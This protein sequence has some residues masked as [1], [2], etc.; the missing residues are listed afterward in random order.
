MQPIFVTGQVTDDQL[1]QIRAAAPGVEVRYF[2]TREE[3]EARIE[4]AEVVAGNIAAP[5]L[6]RATQLRWVQSWAAGPDT[7]MYPEM[8]AS[9]V[10]CT[11]CK[12]NGAIPLAEH[13]MMLMLMLNRDMLR[14]QRAQ[15]DHRWEHRPHRRAERPDLRH[16]R[17]RLF[18]A[19]PGAEVQGVPYAHAR[20]PPHRAADAACR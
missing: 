16:H 11:S 18:G 10:I 13:A 8:V 20:H 5:A 4:E 15:T 2:A 1:A 6:A 7:L 17:A 14:W 3:L 19:G 12:G 9:P